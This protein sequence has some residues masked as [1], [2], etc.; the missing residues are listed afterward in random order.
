M[1]IVDYEKVDNRGGIALLAMDQ[2]FL[3]L[4]VTLLEACFEGRYNAC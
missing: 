2:F 3:K 4:R 1:H